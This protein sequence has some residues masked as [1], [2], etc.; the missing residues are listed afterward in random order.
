MP[1]NRHTMYTINQ[2]QLV[3]AMSGYALHAHSAGFDCAKASSAVEK[4]ICA[5]AQLSELDESLKSAYQQA[6]SN[7]SS[8]SDLKKSQQTWL[9]SV[10][11]RCVETICLTQAYHARLTELNTVEIAGAYQRYHQGKPSINAP[12]TIAVQNVSN[13][14]FNITGDAQWIA[15]PDSVNNGTLSGAYPLKNN[16][17]I[18][19]KD[20]CEISITFTKDGLTVDGDTPNQPMCNDHGAGVSFDGDY[21]KI[22]TADYQKVRVNVSGD[23]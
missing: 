12:A 11:N 8:A 17:I 6:L 7:T 20:T 22:S 4:M 15:N 9:K 23:N 19:G 18:M 16:K 3:V 1:A 14:Q 21:R 10:R 13:G 2:C 5:D